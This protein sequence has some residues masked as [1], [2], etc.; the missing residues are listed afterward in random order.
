MIYMESWLVFEGLTNGRGENWQVMGWLLW[1]QQMWQEIY[2]K[3]QQQEP[4]SL[5]AYPVAA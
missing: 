2:G 5:V 1:G 4:V 3:V